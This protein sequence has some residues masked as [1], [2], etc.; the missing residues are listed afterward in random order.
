LI[1]GLHAIVDALRGGTSLRGALIRCAGMPGSPFAPVAAALAEGRPL[2]PAL[3]AAA[4]G[5]SSPDSASDPE[6]ASAFCVLAVHAEAG[7]D[8]LPA[9]R[10]LADRLTRRAAA[11]EEARAFTTQ[12]RLGARA[13]LL[14]TPAFLLLVAASDPRGAIA[15]FSQPTTRLCIV[16]GLLLQ[17]GG[18]VWVSSIVRGVAPVASSLARL[19]V[20]RALRAIAM[21][22]ARPTTDGDVSACA[23]TL[24]LALEAGLSPTA[25]LRA[26]ASYAGGE[27]GDAI[28][29]AVDEVG[30]PLRD[31]VTHAVA[32]LDGEA[33]QRFARAFAWGAE[34]GI[35]LAHAMRTLSADIDE[36]ASIALAEDSRRASIRVLMPLGLLVLPAFV[37]ACLVPLFVGGLQGI[38]G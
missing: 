28:R 10:A 18:A 5:T 36:R 25:A 26:V 13:I 6:L 4:A 30:V 21:G 14:L 12:A 24:A 7:G 22:R 11:R 23:G 38:A 8:P 3:H 27:F 31:A 32:E 35:P 20:V 33:A 16:L 17:G 34:L 15:W 2:A 1:D 9:I 19:P 29:E 37:L